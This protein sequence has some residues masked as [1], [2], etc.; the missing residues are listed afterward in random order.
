MKYVAQMTTYSFDSTQEDLVDKLLFQELKIY[1]N[2]E[3]LTKGIEEV[4]SI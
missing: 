2:F 4:F 1:T 3:Q